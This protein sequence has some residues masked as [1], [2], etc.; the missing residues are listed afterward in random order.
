MCQHVSPL[1]RCMSQNATAPETPHAPRN[2]TPSRNSGHTAMV[3]TPLIINEM[4]APGIAPKA[5]PLDSMD[6]QR[7][8]FRHRIMKYPGIPRNTTCSAV[9]LRQSS[10]TSQVRIKIY[11][12]LYLSWPY[13]Y[14][15]VTMQAG[16][17]MAVVKAIISLKTLIFHYLRHTAK[18][19]YWP[20]ADI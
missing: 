8:A 6:R 12:S 18:D 9:R 17:R 2:K 13:K 11:G 10:R 15:A 4:I 20:I 16:T 14:Q 5:K 3:G 7:S 1:G 19:R